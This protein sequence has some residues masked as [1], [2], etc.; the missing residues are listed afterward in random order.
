MKGISSRSLFISKKIFP[1][2]G[3]VRRDGG[4]PWL[5]MD[6]ALPS[7]TRRLASNN[8]KERSELSRRPTSQ[9]GALCQ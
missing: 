2:I 7:G 9:V 3:R 8:R 4:M 5:M 6:T 1:L